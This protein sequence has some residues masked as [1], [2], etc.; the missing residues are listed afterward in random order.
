MVFAKP[1]ESQQ[2]LGGCRPDG[3]VIMHSSRPDGVGWVAGSTGIWVQYTPSQS[4]MLLNLATEYNN[5]INELCSVMVSALLKGGAVMD[6]KFNTIR[7]ASNQRKIKYLN[8]KA[9]ILNGV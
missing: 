4:E 8:D 3:W 5:N 7:E 9:N 6:S 1:G 2:Q